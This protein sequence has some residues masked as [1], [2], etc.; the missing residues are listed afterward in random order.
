MLSRVEVSGGEEKGG[1]RGGFL[2]EK[3]CQWEF[4]LSFSVVAHDRV[5]LAA[6]PADSPTFTGWRRLRMP[7]TFQLLSEW[8][9]GMENKSSELDGCSSRRRILHLEMQ[10]PVDGRGCNSKWEQL[11]CVFAILL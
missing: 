3:S 11:T 2:K 10:I 8:T 5:A 6:T 1:G 4:G 7:N 9:N